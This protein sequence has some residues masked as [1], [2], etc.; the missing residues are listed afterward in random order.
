MQQFKINEKNQKELLSLARRSI[1]NYLKTGKEP[2]YITADPLLNAPAAVFV[3]LTE[4][5]ELRGCIGNTVAREPLFKAVIH[6][7]IAAATEDPRFHKVSSSELKDVHIEISVL[8]PFERVSSP[9]EIKQNVHGVIVK[10][11]MRSGLFLPQVW[12][13]FSNKED[14]MGELCCQKAGIDPQAWKD[15]DTELYT[16][17]VVAFEE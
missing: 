16:F 6:M 10:R 5:K 17:T 14:F 4:N 15:P 3:T 13:H 11:G 7:A 12:E 8:S 1:E 9:E 2:E